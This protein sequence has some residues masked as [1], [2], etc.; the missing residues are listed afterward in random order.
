MERLG[1][2]VEQFWDKVNSGR[3]ELGMI[4]GMSVDLVAWGMPSLM[5]NV[6]QFEVFAVAVIDPFKALNILL[7]KH[8]FSRS[9]EREFVASM[10]KSGHGK[11]LRE[12]LGIAPE[13][14]DD[15]QGCDWRIL[16]NP[17]TDIFSSIQINQPLNPLHQ[18]PNNQ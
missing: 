2:S 6:G 5:N 4:V 9:L 12:L 1:I 16:C 15:D 11:R 17:S 10:E 7:D 3:P 14:G 18:K 8:V 13:D